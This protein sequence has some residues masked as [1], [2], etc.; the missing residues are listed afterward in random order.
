[1]KSKGKLLEHCTIQKGNTYVLTIQPS[2]LIADAPAEG[3]VSYHSEA[4][5]VFT[6]SL[7]TYL[8]VYSQLSILIRLSYPEPE[9]MK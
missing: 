3:G 7:F 6:P 2:P 5:G 8:A 4:E 1:M 9:L